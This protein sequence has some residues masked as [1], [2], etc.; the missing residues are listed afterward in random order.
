MKDEM[1]ITMCN[2]MIERKSNYGSS[3]SYVALGLAGGAETD[4][5]NGD[6]SFWHAWLGLNLNFEYK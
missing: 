5:R 2:C 4:G 3:H 1:W 6:P